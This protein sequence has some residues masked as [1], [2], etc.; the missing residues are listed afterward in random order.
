MTIRQTATTF[1]VTAVRARFPA[2]ARVGADGRPFVWADAPG[3]SQTPESVIDAV[4]NRMAAGASNT[5]GV[6]PLSEEIDDVIAE[7]HRAGAGFLGCDPDEVVFG[8]N[9]TSLLLHLSRSF[10]RTLEPGDEVVVTRLDHDANVRPWILA[11]RDA[12]AAVRWVDVR[13]DDVTLDLES[14]ER[15]LSERTRLVA[16][17][18][19]SKRSEPSW[20][21][22]ACTSRST[23][24]STYTRSAPTWWRPRR[25]SSSDLTW[26]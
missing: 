3:G 2:L 7:A 6:F 8:Q 18:L 12:G 1:D 24:R 23:A 22:M 11:A 15:Q 14:F 16:L 4:A 25:T 5:H 20:P 17:T 19:A 9:A 10:S 21:S 26:G 13:D